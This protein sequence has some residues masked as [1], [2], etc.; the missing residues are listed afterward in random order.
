MLLEEKQ[1]IPEKYSRK[2]YSV[3]FNNLEVFK[4]LPKMQNQGLNQTWHHFCE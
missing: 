1:M 3:Y 4:H 2:P